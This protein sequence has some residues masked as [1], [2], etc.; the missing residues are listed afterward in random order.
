[1]RLES[2]RSKDELERRGGIE[3]DVVL[4]L[5]NADAGVA[6]VDHLCDGCAQGE[7]GQGKDSQ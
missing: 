3:L 7:Q 5:E 2:G 1:L 6:G 4:R